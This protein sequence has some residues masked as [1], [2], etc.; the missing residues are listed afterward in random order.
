[1][2]T[3]IKV[4]FQAH[5]MWFGQFYDLLKYRDH[6]F[7]SDSRLPLFDSKSCF[8]DTKKTQVKAFL[9][10][11]NKPEVGAHSD[12]DGWADDSYCAWR[13]PSG[14]IPTN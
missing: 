9:R 5:L 3:A 1:M 4:S 12:V 7:L 11:I 6:F 10:M 2:T 8:R 13:I 14:V